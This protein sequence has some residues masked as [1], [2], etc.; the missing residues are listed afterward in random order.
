MMLNDPRMQV[1]D[2]EGERSGAINDT[3]EPSFE[4]YAMYPSLGT[5]QYR[6]SLSLIV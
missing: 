5:L 2:A 3:T 4:S 1:K 6:G